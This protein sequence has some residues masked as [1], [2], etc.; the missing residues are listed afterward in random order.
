MAH[1]GDVGGPFHTVAPVRRPPPPLPSLETP[2]ARPGNIGIGRYARGMILEVSAE[3][4]RDIA[5]AVHAARKREPAE[6]VIA[7][8]E[9]KVFAAIRANQPSLELG[10]QEAQALRNVLLMR[11]H[12][13]RSSSEAL[14]YSDLADRIGRDLDTEDPPLAEVD[15]PQDAGR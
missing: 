10:P 12:A 14:D 15:N 7:G 3:D 4:L 6:E 8:L 2:T 1:R 9:R 13:Q 11:A 5:A